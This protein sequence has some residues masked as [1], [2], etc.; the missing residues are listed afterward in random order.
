MS[1][2]INSENI[3]FEE[4][5]KILASILP[6]IE[7]TDGFDWYVEKSTIEVNKDILYKDLFGEKEIS[8]NQKFYIMGGPYDNDG[9][10][11]ADGCVKSISESTGAKVT[12]H[13]LDSVHL[14][15][16][17]KNGEMLQE[18][19]KKND[20]KTVEEMIQKLNPEKATKRISVIEKLKNNLNKI[21]AKKSEAPQKEPRQL[22]RDDAR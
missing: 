16:H 20:Y 18:C 19:W 6:S 11:M 22:D 10:D 17:G 8:A 3:P 7:M 9:P 21:E 12:I 5:G 15:G 2:L 13:Q 14:F 4:F 1:Y